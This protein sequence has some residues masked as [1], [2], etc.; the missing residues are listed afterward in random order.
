MKR[1]FLATIL[2]TLAILSGGKAMAQFAGGNGTQNDPYLIATA[3]Q[4]N[5][6]ANT[7]TQ[8]KYYKQ[9]A[10]LT[11][12]YNLF[13]VSKNFKAINFSGHYDGQG[14]SIK[15]SNEQ[16]GTLFNEISDGEVKN[17]VIDGVTVSEDYPTSGGLLCR[18]SAM[19]E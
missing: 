16:Q 5:E 3:E 11:F 14:F 2:S 6:M 17:L 9:T 4:F 12:T 1:L 13:N 8:D 18:N 19:D 10:D 15:S 7:A